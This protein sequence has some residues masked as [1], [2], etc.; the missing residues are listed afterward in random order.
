MHITKSV[1]KKTA[2]ALLSAIL[3]LML[4]FAFNTQAIGSAFAAGESAKKY[5]T[6]FDS[7]E[8]E[9]QVAR[10][11]NEVFA[12]E[13]YVLMKNENNAL[14]LKSS[15]NMISLFATN[16]ETLIYGGSGSGGGNLDNP[17][18]LEQG[19][20]DAGFVLNPRLLEIYAGAGDTAGELPVED[21]V[22][23]EGS[24]AM[25]DGAAVVVISRTGS[26]FN[27]AQMWGLDTHSN[28][29]DQYYSLTDN[30]K[31]LIQYVKGYFD[32]VIVVVNSA[33]PVELGDINDAEGPLSVDAIVWMGL[34]GVTG[35]GALGRVLN[36][37]VNPSGHT[38]D[39]YPR[40]FAQDPTWPNF[41]GNIQSQLY[42]NEEGELVIKDIMTGEEVAA[43]SDTGF[44]SY[45]YLKYARVL[46]ED[47]NIV[48]MD[49]PSAGARYYNTLD[50]EEGI[51]MGYRW[52]ETAYAEI[53]A[54]NYLP[55][56]DADEWYDDNVVYP[57]GYGLSYTTFDWEIVSDNIPDRAF[58]PNGDGTNGDYLEL[59]L[60]VTNTG[61]VAGKDVGEI[62]FSAPYYEGEIE[63]SS[64]TLVEFVKSEL[65]APGESQTIKVSFRYQDMASFDYND[66]NNNDFQGYE[67][68]AGTYTVGVY[69]DSHT[70]ATA[71]DK[72]ALVE[73]EIGTDKKYTKDSTTDAEI[74]TLFTP[75]KGDTEWDGTRSDGQWY[76]S[77]RSE[78]VSPESQM[79]QLSRADFEGTYPEAPTKEDLLWSDEAILIMDNQ[80]YY[81]SFNDLPSDPW[82]VSE[83]DIPDS[84]TQA[85][86]EDVANRVDG[87]TEIQLYEM[88]G[89]PFDDARWDTFMN[90][91]T[92]DEMRSL[93]TSNRFNTPA[94]EAIGKE[95]STDADGPAQLSDGTFWVCE[96]NIASTWNVD[97]AYKQG[98]LVG[99][100]SLYQGVN[101]WYGPGMNIHR[102]P[103]AGRNFEY[104]SQDGLHSGKIAAAVIKGATDMGVVVYMKHLFMNDQETNRYTAS[105]FCNEQ[106]IREICAKPWELA[107]KDGNANASM[108]AF[109][110]IGLLDT[111][112][113]Y[114]LYEGLLK[115]E[116]GFQG[117]S[118]TDMFGWGYCPGDSG[119]MGARTAITPL[120]T[121]NDTFG[122]N[123]E[124]VWDDEK[125]T[126]VCTFTE[127]ITN[128]TRWTKDDATGT[129]STA[130]N[131]SN[132]GNINTI[133]RGG[134]A[135]YK[136]Q[137]NLLDTEGLTLYQEGDTIES[138]TQWSAVRI[139]AQRLLWAQCNGNN[140]KNGVD[141]SGF[142]GNDAL[143]AVM[144]TA[145]NGSVAPASETGATITE[146]NVTAGTLPAGLTIGADGSI[147]GT[148]TV[149][150]TYEFTVTMTA[151]TFVTA[152]A[153]F[154]I[155]IE[156]AFELSAPS[157][158]VNTA[159]SG[160]I[161][162]DT[163]N[164]AAGYS[165]VVYALESG[166]LPTGLTLNEDGTITGTAAEA[167]T[168][169][170]TVR[171]D[172]SRRQGW[173]TIRASYYEDFTIDVT[174][175][176]SEGP[177]EIDQLKE[178]L[179]ALAAQLE[180][181]EGEVGAIDTSS[182]QAAIDALEN[183]VGSIDISSLQAAIDALEEQVGSMDAEAIQA[184]IDALEADV[185]ALQTADEG[186]C[187]S[188]IG[189]SS[190]VLGALM[191]TAGAVVVAKKRNNK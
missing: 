159:Y 94:L 24:Y 99:N 114:N 95:R 120:G 23:A 154:T 60:R 177:S 167:G 126:V 105:T 174:A 123:V 141:M 122:R 147:T 172:T 169:N 22:A 86:E 163:I 104:Y 58:T 103:A 148:P 29:L 57:F 36:G 124:G 168:Y 130:M 51:Y 109:N 74:T 153:D 187:G 127:D 128:G 161:T 162:S 6:D 33:H 19:L 70:V 79:T 71:G 3:A 181:L 80:V 83:E 134:L 85:S 188:V 96:V 110:R 160:G 137:T 179:A 9:K 155:A 64:V 151:D 84:W 131:A 65:L 121:W 93:I 185:E 34:P 53:E 132:P 56:T 50:Y 175:G 75:D 136:G 140:S 5:F 27:D 145:Y 87:K 117:S 37:E 2:I 191:L 119:D 97:L 62:Y 92:Y 54:G 184:A 133:N 116:F 129:E 171:V 76:D 182:L 30:E 180:A 150:G 73:F 158:A 66:A 157:I 176:G 125:Q 69:E 28:P 139:A 31:E 144:G 88:S 8:E 90:Q 115:K 183:E 44:T 14:P 46:D 55:G 165:S 72:A 152:T 4:L 156:S 41:K 11:L 107:I 111:T 35:A 164:T 40:Y 32:K 100:E 43:P 39:V 15:E 17:I 106:A 89:I 45:E 108:A 68:E 10:D 186:G 146:Y 102:N 135:A 48:T 173:S 77:V 138:Y 61:S 18:Y 98:R 149:S 190:I 112:S 82:Y 67:L 25:Y 91:L 142:V 81:T 52:Y 118:V 78:F 21:L 13:S 38:S 143:E 1:V 63:K 7:Y 189:A 47:G 166:A 178:Q 113:H 170:F 12:D 16:S 20:Q 101:G 59:E 26:E 42:L 49:G